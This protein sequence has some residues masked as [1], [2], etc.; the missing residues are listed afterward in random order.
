M[1]NFISSAL[2]ENKFCIGIFLDLKK[3][4]DVVPHSILLKKLKKFG[5]TGTTWN[6]FR[7]YLSNRKQKVE[8]NGTFSNLASINISVLQGSILGPILFLCFINDLPNLPNLLLLLF[9]DDT[10]CFA[11]DKNLN[12]LIN[13]CNTE[14]QKDR[15]SVV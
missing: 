3:A 9:A 15:K 1:T 4:F 5:I 2:N 7:S 10:G 12:N 14:L 11:S 6:W 13:T 8:I